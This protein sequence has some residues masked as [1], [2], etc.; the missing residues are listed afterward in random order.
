LNGYIDPPSI[1]GLPQMRDR[2]TSCA[3][4]EPVSVRRLRLASYLAALLVSG[5]SACFAQT[6]PSSAPTAVTSAPEAA[7]A[8]SLAQLAA[9]FEKSPDA[10]VAEV[11][12]TPLTA[13]MVAD[14]LHDFPGKFSALPA[15]LVYKGALDDLIQQ[16]ALAVKAK[17]LGLDKI[18]ETQRRIAEATDRTLAQ[19]LVQQLVP[20]MVTDKGVENIYNSTI[21]GRP[22]PEEVQFRVI[23]AATEA[24]ARDLLDVLARGA[25]FAALAQ[26]YS[27]DPSG[28]TGGEIDYAPR[29]RL[30][31]EIG[32]VVFALQPGQTT[33]FPVRAAGM[34]FI[35]RVEGRRQ[36]GTPTLAETRAIVSAELAQEASAEIYRKARAAVVVHDYGP[37]G[38]Q[39]HD[40]AAPQK[41]Q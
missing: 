4:C 33:A 24:E 36:Q 7:S 5:G 34:W 31:P 29:N 41:S 20:Q 3:G 19:M 8:G 35:L 27:K 32:A 21:A 2:V 13:G 25:D 16:R 28:L 38:M 10:I 39:R 23:A 11:N 1:P 14:R 9:Q 22:G 30:G 18:P 12:D 26:K 6:P 40:N 17:E 15:P 37:T